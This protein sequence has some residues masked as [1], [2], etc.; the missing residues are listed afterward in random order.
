LKNR[1]RTT[2]DSR[3]SES[4][5]LND[6]VL[7]LNS[8]LEKASKGIKEQMNKLSKESKEKV[9]E[10]LLQ[11]DRVLLKEEHYQ[12]TIDNMAE[13]HRQELQALKDLLITN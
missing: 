12:K 9:E 10:A 2:I 5:G 3:E 13:T 1:L 7:R 4:R 6:E 11:R 8:Q